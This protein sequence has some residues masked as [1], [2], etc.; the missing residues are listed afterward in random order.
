MFEKDFLF[1]NATHKLH[2]MDKILTYVYFF[3]IFIYLCVMFSEYMILRKHI[4]KLCF[5]VINMPLCY[6]QNPTQMYV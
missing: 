4:L 6:F 2:V 5:V 3:R 1:G